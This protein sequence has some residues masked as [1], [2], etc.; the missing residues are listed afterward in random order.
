MS[1]LTRNNVV[2]KAALCAAFLFTSNPIVA[3][4]NN[5]WDIFCIENPQNIEITLLAKDTRLDLMI[6]S[7]TG[8]SMRY[9]VSDSGKF[10][11]TTSKNQLPLTMTIDT[12]SAHQQVS[13]SQNCKKEVK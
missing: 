7:S 1:I 4:D 13:M 3:R 6:M 10:T 11:Y 8:N 12:L 5:S 9:S 2:V